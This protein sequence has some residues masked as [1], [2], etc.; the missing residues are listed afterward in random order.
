MF[1]KKV[2]KESKDSSFESLE[3]PVNT[4]IELVKGLFVYVNQVLKKWNVSDSYYD[5]N[6]FVAG[7]LNIIVDKNKEKNEK[8]SYFKTGM[9]WKQVIDGLS[10]LI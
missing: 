9:N 8:N 7:Y 10:A 1:R 4:N 3:F 2:A 6:N 5:I